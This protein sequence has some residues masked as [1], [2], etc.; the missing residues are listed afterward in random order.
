MKSLISLASIASCL[1]LATIG[2]AQE[3][4][5]AHDGA[6]ELSKEARSARYGGTFV[7]GDQVKVV[8]VTSTGN[9]GVGVEEYAFNA[10]L[11]PGNIA[12]RNVDATA[13]EKEFVWYIPQEKAEHMI[14]SDGKWLKAGAAFGGGMK[15]WRG[16]ITK[17][18]TLGVYTGMDF[19]SEEEIRPKTGDIWRIMPGG[20]KS[21]SDVD[22]IR[23]EYG[24]YKELERFGRD[25]MM[26]AND[27][28]LASGVITEKV[29]IRNPPSTA[30]NRVA[31][32]S[33]NGMDFDDM[34]Y[35]IYMLPFTALTVTSGLGQDDD[36]CS[37]FAPLNGPT[38]LKS[39]HHLYWKD[40]KD[41]FTVMR[42]SDD[43]QLVDS[44][45]F[46]SG[47]LWGNYQIFNSQGSTYVTGLGNADFSGWYRGLEYKKLNGIEVARVKDG[48][49]VYAKCFREDELSS[50]LVGPAGEKVKFDLYPTNSSIREVIDLPNGDALL[51]GRSP[52][53]N[54]A[55][56]LS[57][58]GDLRAFY[59]IPPVAKEGTSVPYN[60]QMVSKGGMLYLVLN[61]QPGEFFT[62]AKVE[63][64]SSSMS[65]N[66][67]RTTITTTTVTKLN[68]V[69]LCS[70][71]V[72]IDPGSATMS[73]AVRM[74]G[75]DFYPMGSFPAL[76]TN[77]AIYFTGR[78][79]GP[80]GK[81]IHVARIDM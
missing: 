69:F 18:Y 37:L 74:G 34:K 13:A 28:M 54:Y 68:E 52:V 48:Q 77:D 39:L 31:V 78:E 33:I 8:Y 3:L 59:F 5:I 72:R 16:T 38:T 41:H 19:S 40:N 25:L 71:V 60:Y 17:S 80:K 20:Y 64:S 42:F 70:Q 50:K 2:H 10:A 32:L 75:K 53:D 44:A 27:R 21:L 56:Q 36:L 61:E 24:F 51:L 35:E 1:L 76:F 79:D 29:S 63:T 81:R 55:L 57:P 58:T 14:G 67:I 15:L 45:S 4:T 7:D 12:E 49:V 73:N 62:D 30:A 46:I 11:E 66:G 23:T 43:L 47:L 22:A 26:P 9:D 65:A 6:A